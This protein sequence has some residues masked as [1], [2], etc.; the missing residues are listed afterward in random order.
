MC[1]GAIFGR[2]CAEIP[3]DLNQRQT[4]EEFNDFVFGNVSDNFCVDDAG[5]E[6][7]KVDVFFTIIIIIIF[8]FLFFFFSI[9]LLIFVIIII[10][11]F[12][13]FSLLFFLFKGQVFGEIDIGEFGV[14]VLG[15]FVVGF[16]GEVV[17]PVYFSEV[18]HVG[19]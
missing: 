18:L 11:F 4:E 19:D 12:F 2:F 9:L 16:F 13:F 8:D 5:V 1:L 7:E 17:G 3:G 6:R 15:F 10:F 14:C